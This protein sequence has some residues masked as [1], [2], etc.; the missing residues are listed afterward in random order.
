MLSINEIIHLWTAVVDEKIRASTGFEPVTSAILTGAML[1]QLSY[2]ATHWERGQFTEFISPVRN[3]MIRSIYLIIHIWTVVVDESEEWSS[4][5]FLTFRHKSKWSVIV[6]WVLKF[7][8]RGVDGKHCLRFG[9]ETSDFNF[10]QRSVDRPKELC[11]ILIHGVRTCSSTSVSRD[12]ATGWP[13]RLLYRKLWKFIEMIRSFSTDAHAVPASTV[14][15]APRRYD[16]MKPPT[17]EKLCC[18]FFWFWVEVHSSLVPRRHWISAVNGENTGSLRR[19]TCGREAWR[20]GTIQEVPH[21]KDKRSP[22]Q[23]ICKHSLIQM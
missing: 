14:C 10:L 23:F 4:Q 17:R 7:L 12:W 5:S 16:R 13:S 2:E 3:E 1:Y 15:K 11:L 22:V 8:R 19:E 6:C 18:C 21:I 9:I 20:L